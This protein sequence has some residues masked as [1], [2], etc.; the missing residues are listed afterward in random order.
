MET[1]PAEGVRD[2][3]RVGVYVGERGRGRGGMCRRGGTQVETRKWSK[4]ARAEAVLKG[5]EG[6]WWAGRVVVWARGC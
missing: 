1:L 3:A 4:D 5:G 2:G 6:M